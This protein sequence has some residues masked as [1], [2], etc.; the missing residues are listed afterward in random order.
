V[1]TTAP[2]SKAPSKPLPQI[3]FM[4][5]AMA[6]ESVHDDTHW[7]MLQESME[8]LHAK[9]EAQGNKLEHG[10]TCNNRWWLRWH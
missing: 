2:K 6:G 10:T 4:L 5:D 9:M 7:V 3:Q 1:I 8:L